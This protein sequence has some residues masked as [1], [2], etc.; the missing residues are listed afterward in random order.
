M[1]ALTVWTTDHE[2]NRIVLSSLIEGLRRCGVSHVVRR[3]AD[4]DGCPVP[5]ISYGVL[6]G[7]GQIYRDCMEAGVPWWNIDKGFFHPG[8]F[9]G[10]Y[11][12][13]YRHL[14]PLFHVDADGD[15]RRWRALGIELQPWVHRPE[16][17]T[18]VCP[19]EGICD[20]YGLEQRAWLQRVGRV[21]PGDVFGKMVV[22]L[23]TSRTPLSAALSLARCVVT[24]SSN[25]AIEAIVAG[26]PAYADTG[27]VRS[28]NKMSFHEADRWQDHLD[29]RALC[30]QAANSQFTL[31]EFRSG[32]A[33]KMTTERIEKEAA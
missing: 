17:T 1:D 21:L 20:F 9:S 28:W 25:V 30:I 23:R 22:R 26:I 10:Y 7:A 11:R 33:W 31:D 4:Y 19:P 14:Q 18:L 8:H 2:Y 27:M 24:H 5:S 15:D 13:G 16:G 32:L 29:R 6:R 3:A 12:I